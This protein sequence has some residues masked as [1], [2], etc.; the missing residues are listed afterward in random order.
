LGQNS[1]GPRVDARSIRLGF[2]L[3]KSSTSPIN[4]TMVGEAQC[5]RNRSKN[6]VRGRYEVND[7]MLN[8]GVFMLNVNDEGSGD[9]EL[10]FNIPRWD[11]EIK[12]GGRAL[13]G[14][15]LQANSTEV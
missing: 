6:Q 15:E 2:R 4:Q 14:S 7:H 11:R 9:V 13:Q 10:L 12:I 1:L 5:L 8:H 3:L